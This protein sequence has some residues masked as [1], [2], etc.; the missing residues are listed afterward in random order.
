MNIISQKDGALV[1]RICAH[2]YWLS[3]DGALAGVSEKHDQKQERARKTKKSA[4]HEI[5]CCQ[6]VPTTMTMART[7]I[8][9]QLE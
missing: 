7:K 3:K 5:L 4:R 6:R 2:R 9:T 8:I 1:K